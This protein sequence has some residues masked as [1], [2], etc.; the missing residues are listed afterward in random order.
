MPQ[1]VNKGSKLPYSLLLPER[2]VKVVCEAI[3]LSPRGFTATLTMLSRKS[4]LI[5]EQAHEKLT[6]IC[7]IYRAYALT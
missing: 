3:R 4:L 1:A 5:T 6:S 7:Q 2:T